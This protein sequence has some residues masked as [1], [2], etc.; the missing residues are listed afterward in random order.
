MKRVISD[1]KAAAESWHRDR[2]VGEQAIV[3]KQ[4]VGGLVIPQWRKR[5][6]RSPAAERLGTPR[7]VT[8]VAESK[9]GEQRIGGVARPATPPAPM[10]SGGFGGFVRRQRHRIRWLAVGLEALRGQR[11][12]QVQAASMGLGR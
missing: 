7:T 5:R 9:A 10:A 3:R 1:A 12:Y 8:P 6:S 11:L 4:M 2:Q